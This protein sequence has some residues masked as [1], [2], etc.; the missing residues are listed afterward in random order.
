M[1]PQLLPPPVALDAANRSITLHHQ[2]MVLRT[3]AAILR[4]KAQVLLA[5][6]QALCV[7]ARTLDEEAWAIRRPPADCPRVAGAV[8]TIDAHR[9]AVPRRLTEGR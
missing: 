2:A 5:E 7:E 6:A 4:R 8:P 9:A 1:T 3:D